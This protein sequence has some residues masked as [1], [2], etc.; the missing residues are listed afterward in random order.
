MKFSYFDDYQPND[1]TSDIFLSEIPLS[2]MKENVL[3]QFKDPLANKKKDHLTTF[4]TMYQRTKEVLEEND[5]EDE[6]DNIVELR[7]DF[8]SF[9]LGLFESFLGLGVDN[10]EGMSEEDQ[11][12]L[13]H[14]TYRFF[15]INIKR[16]FVSYVLN[17]LNDNRHRFEVE[18]QEERNDVTALSLKKYISDEVD[19]YILSN[20]SQIIDDILH[21]DIDVDEFFSNCDTEDMTLETTF[22][23]SMFDKFIL[24]GNFVPYYIE[25]LDND[26]ISEIETKVRNKIVKKYKKK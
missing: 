9:V 12:D 16:N 1:I 4:I 19:L 18:A 5:D 22:V 13:I 21:Q 7:D 2:L 11:D 8:Y 14:Y 24:T 15:I 20:L 25:M 17:F 3:S 6:V 23:K 10:F 26:F